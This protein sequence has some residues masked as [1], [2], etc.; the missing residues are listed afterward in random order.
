VISKRR[1]MLC[2]EA[3]SKARPRVTPTLPLKIV[4]LLPE[5]LR[6]LYSSDVPLSVKL[7]KSTKTATAMEFLRSD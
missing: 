6:Q 2:S 7:N 4:R 3:V 5:V 1:N